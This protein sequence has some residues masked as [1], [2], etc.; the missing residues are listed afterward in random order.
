MEE[1][2]EEEEYENAGLSDTAG[3][4]K[5]FVLLS[6]RGRR[7]FHSLLQGSRNNVAL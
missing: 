5:W 7:S 1:E 4:L 2:E 6:I 3:F